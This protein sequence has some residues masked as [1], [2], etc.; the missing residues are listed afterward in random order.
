M[1]HQKRMSNADRAHLQWQT[2]ETDC[3]NEPC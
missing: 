1:L 3:K 2:I